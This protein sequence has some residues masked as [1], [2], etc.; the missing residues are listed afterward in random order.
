MADQEQIARAQR[1]QAK[2]LK[3]FEKRLD[4]GTISAAEV[5][6]LS[7]L[8]MANGWS[9]DPSQLPKSIRD[10]LPSLDPTKFEDDD[11]DLPVN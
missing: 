9:L 10:L 8:L 1:L 7:R 6:T 3:L 2:L 5:S 11:P 4:D